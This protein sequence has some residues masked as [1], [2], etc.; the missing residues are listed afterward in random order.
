MVVWTLGAG[1]LHA[2][3]PF[4]L[5]R[6]GG[7]AQR[8]PASPAVR[9]AGL[10]TVATGGALM[11]WAFVAHYQQAPQGWPM[12]SGLTPGYLLRQ[13]PYRLIRN[14]MYAGEI[15]AW[16]GWGLVYASPAVWTGLAI[17]GAGLA[18]TVRWEER[19]LLRRFGD[20]YR[21]YLAEVPRWVPGNVSR[22]RA[23][24]RG[25]LRDPAP[26]STGRAGVWAGG[27]PG[28]CS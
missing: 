3:V 19:L 27:Q 7:R 6:L 17:M 9:S 28:S 26:Q 16:A 13:G 2:A 8:A 12:E 14:P 10:V 5:A 11:G 23:K 4:Q 15:V 24:R 22:R 20:D 25:L 1:A 18:P 21:A